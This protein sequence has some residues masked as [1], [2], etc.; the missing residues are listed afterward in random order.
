MTGFVYPYTRDGIGT[1]SRADHVSVRTLCNAVADT[2][3]YV[4]PEPYDGIATDTLLNL[5][6]WR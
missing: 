5:K 4:G 3:V 6:A 2:K 1:Y